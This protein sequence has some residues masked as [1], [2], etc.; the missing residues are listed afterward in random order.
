MK[1]RLSVVKNGQDITHMF[2]I[3]ANSMTSYGDVGICFDNL[4][5]E[6]ELIEFLK[7]HKLKYNYYS[8][9][10]I[11]PTPRVLI[12]CAETMTPIEEI[13]KNKKA[14]ELGTTLCFKY[15]ELGCISQ[16]TDLCIK[17]EDQGM[18]RY[19]A[20]LKAQEEMDRI[21]QKQ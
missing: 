9:V 4:Q 10:F 20:Y 16:F 18:H 14:D 2:D 1:I 7:K 5:N 6:Q 8:Q 13:E 11:E 12:E 17:Y 19:D 21:I 15:I 3:V